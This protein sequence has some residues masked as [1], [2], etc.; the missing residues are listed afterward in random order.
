V[1]DVSVGV[2]YRVPDGYTGDENATTLEAIFGFYQ[3][4]RTGTGSIGIA[5]SGDLRIWNDFSSIY[6]AGSRVIDPTMGGLFDLPAPDL[7]VKNE[8]LG[9]SASG[10]DVSFSHGGGN[11]SISAGRDITR[12]ALQLDSG[13]GGYLYDASGKNKAVAASVTQMPSNW[14][15]RRGAVDPATGLFLKMPGSDELASTAW[16]VDFSNFFQGVGALGGGNVTMAAARN[17]ANVDAVIPTNL[18][19]PSRDLGGSTWSNP[20]P[21]PRSSLV[22]AI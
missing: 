1:G 6:T 16:W 5:A 13:T 2:P 21:L 14:L 4:I 10:Y 19:M 11:V 8:N 17:V 18:R 3:P 20:T 22:A 9:Y 7:S 15:L 12:L